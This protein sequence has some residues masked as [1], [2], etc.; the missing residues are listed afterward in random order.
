M[1]MTPDKLVLIC[2]N[3][4][5]VFLFTRE[6]LLQPFCYNFVY[7]ILDRT[8]LYGIYT[9]KVDFSAVHIQRIIAVYSGYDKPPFFSFNDA[10]QPTSLEQ[11]DIYKHLGKDGID[12][13]DAFRYYD[14][15]MDLSDTIYGDFDRAL[16]DSSALKF[17][18]D[19]VENTEHGSC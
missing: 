6:Y 16:C 11:P 5:Y 4:G 9:I 18:A 8:Y 15:D 3:D 10:T 17:D 12:S 19:F 7:K 14:F 2:S 13:I 1:S